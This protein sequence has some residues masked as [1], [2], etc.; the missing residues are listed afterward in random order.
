[1]FFFNP[2]E[3]IRNI[4]KLKVF[5]CFQPDQK[6]PL[7]KKGLIL[8]SNSDL[9][10]KSIILNVRNAYVTW[11]E[12]TVKC[13]VQISTQN[14]AQSFG[15]FGQMVECSLTKWFWVRVQLQLYVC[16]IYIIYYQGFIQA[17]CWPPFFMK[18]WVLWP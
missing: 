5:W 11:Q 13:T 12:H 16:I 15:Q 2:T 4:R 9:Y 8:F 10:L 3:N 1:M 18:D 17:F 14:T 7:G 6:G